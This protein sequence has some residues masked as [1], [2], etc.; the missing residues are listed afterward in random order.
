[1]SR[2]DLRVVH[3]TECAA[4]GTLQVLTCLTRELAQAGARQTLVYSPRA[5]TPTN[6]QQ[7][8]PEGVDFV[9]VPP[10]SGLHLDFAR[11][12]HAA[13]A[14][15]MRREAPDVLHLH[16]SKAGFIGRVAQLAHRWPA[17]VF[18]S[19][20]GLSYL[21]PGKPATNLLFRSLE[22]L[23]ARTGA[24]PVGCGAGEAGLLSAL[25]GREALL[26]ENPVDDFFFDA[27][28]EPA[29][30]TSV[31]TV[32]RLSRQKAPETFAAVARAVRAR[33]PAATFT[34]IGDGEPEYRA[35]LADAG[36]EL[37][38][39]RDR[40]GVARALAN[41]QVYLQ[42]SRWEGLPVSV[43]QAQAMGIP[44]VVNDCIG[45][46][47]A[48]AHQ[49]TGYVEGSV[50]MLALR[51][52]MLLEDPALA[53][54]LGAAARVEAERR[55]SRAA[56]RTQVRR[57]YGIPVTEVAPGALESHVLPA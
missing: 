20:H 35:V 9:P 46:R 28:R 7:L 3:A 27:G 6:L 16:S 39:W 26:L 50:D 37:T 5:E 22:W 49:L 52:Q 54:R 24:T 47:D 33:H 15:T 19:P 36:C 8:F 23:A 21:D 32:G 4:S 13:L 41:A 38:G 14:R 31:V 30:A 45:N 48:V 42:T 34:W 18:Y 53:A 40:A 55:F 11:E 12:F 10:A 56:F 2:R 1:M 51:V 43:L 29:P 44:C 25:G 17:R 57:L